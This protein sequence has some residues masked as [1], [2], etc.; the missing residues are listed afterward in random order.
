MPHNVLEIHPYLEV[1][2]YEDYD[3]SYFENLV[4]GSFPI[5]AITDRVLENNQ[6]QEVALKENSADMRFFYGSKKNNFW[7]W[8]AKAFN[9]NNPL[10]QPN[11]DLRKQAAKELLVANKFLIT[12]VVYKTNRK[13]TSALDNDLWVKTNSQLVLQNRSLYHNLR[14]LLNNN[15][16][17]KNLYFT[18]TGLHGKTPFGWFN[19]IFGNDLVF[20]NINVI[21]NNTVSATLTINKRKYNAFF[22]ITPGGGWARRIPFTGENNDGMFSNYLMDIDADFY[23]EIEHILKEN[24]TKTQ[25]DT[26][27]GLRKQYIEHYYTQLLNAKNMVFDGHTVSDI[28]K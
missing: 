11:P 7:S 18:A 9:T 27:K 19:K 23:N 2:N 24:R 12:D 4:I 26:L 8:L 5:Q 14:N 15:K 20:Q 13:N 21:H 10:E 6:I 17:I 1:I 28:R 16:A 3:S 25:E 22:L